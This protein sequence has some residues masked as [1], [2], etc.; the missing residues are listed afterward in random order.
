VKGQKGVVVMAAT[1]KPALMDPAIMRPGRFDKIFYI[2]PPE[3]NGRADIFKIHLGAFSKGV[4]LDALAKATDGF[5]GAD[6]AE[7]CQSAKMK[8]LRAKLAKKP[9]AVTSQTILGIIKTRRPSITEDLLDEYK[10]FLKAYGER[11]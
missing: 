9:E 8:A 2:P 4:D 7:V 11:R 3:E 6:I 1:N 5:S 10:R